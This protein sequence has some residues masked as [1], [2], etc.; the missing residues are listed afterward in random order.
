MPRPLRL[1]YVVPDLG[2]GGAERHVTTLLPRLDPQ[3]FTSCAVCI[4][5]PGAL[6]SD[7]V[8]SSIPATALRR[9]KRQMV[10]ALVDLVREMRRFRPDIVITRGYNAETLGRAAAFL[11]RVPHVVVWV[12]HCGD[13]EPRG[14][15]RRLIDR[16]LD[17]LTDSYF[18]V[19]EAQRAF[20]TDDLGY[21]P[22]K[23]T[24]VYNGVDPSLYDTTD[25][26]SVLPEL[27]VPADAP[28]VGIV[29]ALR[30][31]KDH[32]CFL[33]AARRVV[34]VRPDVRFLVIGDG[35]CRENLA[36]IADA[37]GLRANIVF[38]GARGDIPR[39]LRALDLVVLSSYSIECFPMALLE[40]MASGRPAVCTAVGGVPEML[41]DGVTGRLVPARDE[42]ALAD[43]MLELLDDP[44]LARK[45]GRAAR[46]RVESE[47]TLLRSVEGAQTAL[48]EAARSGIVRPARSR[49][50]RPARS[51]IVR[52]ARSRIVRPARPAERAER[53][54][55]VRLTLVLDQTFVGGVEVLMLE[56][57]RHLDPSVVRPRLVCLREAGPLAEEYRR[58]GFEVEVVPRSGRYDPRRL[59]RLVRML[60]TDRTDAVLVTHHHHAALALG[61][62]A[63]RIAGTPTN[64]VAA[65]DMDL[66]G[67]GKRCLPR[68]AVST[69]F[70]SDALVLLGPRQGDYLRR[71]E[72]VAR[73]P[74]SRTR[75]VVITNGID[76]GD[77]PTEE[78]RD[79]ARAALG[80]S[81][82]AFAVGIVAR[83]SHQK[84][85]QVLFEAV[86]IAARTR[87]ELQLLVIG[88]GERESELR[89]LAG[90]LGISGRTV[91]TGVRRD[92][93]ALL[94]GLDVSALSSVHEGA[95]ITVIEAMAAGLPVV[96]T[97]C[98]C[99]PDM[100]TDG[101]DGFLVPVGDAA[102]LAER[103]CV[104]AAD[105]SLARR[106][107]A[108]GRERAEREYRISRTAR[109]F[110]AL[111]TELTGRSS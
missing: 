32:A 79:R 3:R 42:R 29:A 50:V 65:H 60:R 40:A 49:I 108:S 96:A 52:P 53:T 51:R 103:L 92:V 101:T 2:V 71:E 56:V 47:F 93:R 9:T 19:A 33:R 76:I 69:L 46:E 21:P 16:C 73:R 70:L 87:P 35:P 54:D 15:L 64:L 82:D 99:L 20:M 31:E 95:P 90:D 11:A 63:A 7:L 80:L 98:G 105:R 18:G 84:A 36:A 30:P 72:G 104:L 1:M 28:T 91:F 24:V 41:V 83:L 17:P 59:T 88:G 109:S 45:M 106:L 4:G 58:A 38:T 100:V 14:R 62:L 55:P 78:D 107:G 77:P 86:R 8:E 61:R 25:D 66:T 111:L 23:I 34:D 81:P 22:E 43:G 37:A 5:E 89:S 39:I 26:P 110:E 6:F 75:E 12:H 44:E 102:A 13:P 57:F 10:R 97:E 67:I 27:G 74:W 94:P 68:W 48:V 85:H